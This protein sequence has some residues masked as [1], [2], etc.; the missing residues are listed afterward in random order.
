ML[1]DV[2]EKSER[3]D[4][5][6]FYFA[7]IV[8]NYPLST[9]AADAKARLVT[10]KMPVPQPDPKA[11]EWMTAEQ[12]VSRPRET[13][14]HRTMGILHNGPDVHTAANF[15]HPN[16]IPE[17]ESDAN[18]D[19]LKGGATTALS[20]GTGPG[21]NAVV[22]TV[23]PGQPAP[24]GSPAITEDVNAPA[25][26]SATPAPADTT[27]AP[28]TDP[29]AGVNNASA[30]PDS[31]SGADASAAQADAAKSDAAASTPPTNQ[32]ESSSKKKGLK[33]LVPW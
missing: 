16:L 15:G 26:D 28:A 10:F 8:R 27:T 11:V 24:A 14:L 21:S 3:K 32:K 13:I 33:K 23:Q 19:T 25:T 1:G 30:A 17:A 31:S 4:L 2:F 20:I 5:S 18:T 29:A 9:H 22:D 12:N 6:G 7:Q